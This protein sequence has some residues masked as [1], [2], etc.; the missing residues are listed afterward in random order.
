MKVLKEELIL[1][2]TAQKLWS[3]LSDISRCDWVPTINEITLDGECRIFE[4]EGMGIVKEKILLNDDSKM[5][6]QYSAIETRT[7][8]DHH[9]ATMHVTEID[10][11][12]CTLIWTTGEFGG[13]GLEGAVK[14]GFKK[15]LEA[16]QDPDEK[17]KLYEKLVSN[18]YDA[19][20]AVEVASFLEIDAVI[21]PADTRKVILKALSY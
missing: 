20:K 8:I 1:N 3:I 6:L 4:M 12:S 11:N 21:D 13:M 14:L 10:E 5:M 15:E 19:G 18:M 2:C 9:L 7:P 17:E 16:I